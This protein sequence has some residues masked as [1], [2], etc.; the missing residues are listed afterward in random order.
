VSEETLK[1]AKQFFGTGATMSLDFRRQQLRKL[2]EVVTTREDVILEALHADLRKPPLEAYASELHLVVGEIDN[3]LKNLKQWA[4][5][6][7]TRTPLGLQPGRSTVR[8][9]PLGVVLIFGPWNYPVQLLLGPLAAALAAGN[10][11][12]LKPSELT[13]N[14]SAMLKRVISDTF[15]EE[16]VSVFE[17]GPDAARHLLD[18]K[19]DHI[20]FTGSSAVG[21]LVMAAAARH[22]TPV[23]LELGGKSPCIVWRDTDCDV[24]ARRIMW[25]KTLNCGQTCV[26]PDYVLIHETIRETFC[27]AARQCCD[28]FFN[29]NAQ[30]SADYGRIVNLPHFERLVRYL[31]DGTIVFG[32]QHDREDLYLEPTLITVDDCNAPV[33]QEEI[34]GPILP[35]IAVDSIEEAIRFVRERP[36]PLALYLFTNEPAIE[37][38]VL[39]ETSSGGVCVNDTINHL[40]PRGLPFGGVGDSGFGR[41]HGKAGF[42]C[43]S[44]QKST[45]RRGLAFDFRL[46]YPPYT[47]SLEFLKRLLRWLF[48]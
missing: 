18:Q 40:I 41:Y 44:N 45:L 15:P 30:T 47:I 5:P 36:K 37:Q 10:C 4:R 27:E 34:F 48:R 20:F 26:A 12:V 32:G 43:F 28:A 2:R 46:K 16:V 1:K 25:G 22:L 9:E 13:P 39:T 31:K 11:A 33:M 35:V 3:A 24:A 6:R 19:F 38:R 42:D 17:G 23:T 14:V 29:G 8:Q 21:R 7:R